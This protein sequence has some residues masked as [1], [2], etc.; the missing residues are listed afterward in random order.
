MNCPRCNS[1]TQKVIDSRHDGNVINRRRKC[2]KCGHKWSTMEAHRNTWEN[3]KE[4]ESHHCRLM[5]A[6][7]AMESKMRKIKV[8]QDVN[9]I[10]PPKYRPQ[11]GEV[12][13]ADYSRHT[14][15]KK[16][17]CVI[18]I[19]DKRVVL[20]SGEFELMEE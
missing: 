10:Y 3:L 12:Y 6:V 4:A 5:A 7:A 20:R 18:T 15:K 11:K 9:E 13:D 14:N 2:L 19:L 16:E 17:F 8:T 1:D